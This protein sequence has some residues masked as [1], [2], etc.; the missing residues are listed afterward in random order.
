[1]PNIH[2]RDAV[3][4]FNI[5]VSIFG[6]FIVLVWT[7]NPPLIHEDLFWRKPLVG[8]IFSLIC[9]MGI[10]A[11]LIPKQCSKSFHFQGETAGFDSSLINAASHHPDC[12][13]FSAHIIHIKG[14]KFCAACTGLLLGAITAIFGTALYFFIGW[15]IENGF[16]A[17]LAGEVATV[18]GFLQLGFRG[19]VRSVLNVLFVLGAFLILVGVDQLAENLF[20][21]LFLTVLIGF[22]ILTRI[23]LS[24]WDHSRICRD[25][26]SPCD[27]ADIGRK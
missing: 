20:V 2:R 7:L 14:L 11:A 3:L 23:Q 1:M 10:L 24:Q 19:I 17:V 22:W 25:C 8:S 16:L 5:S 18:L 9:L 12:E 13:E 21:D 27:I 15:P 6:L 4:L 26:K